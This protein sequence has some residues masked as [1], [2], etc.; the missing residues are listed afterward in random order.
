MSRQFTIGALCPRKDLDAERIVIVI[1][2]SLDAFNQIK[3]WFEL[4]QDIA[5]S[6]PSFIGATFSD[7]SLWPHL[8]LVKEG[9]SGFP[10]DSNWGKL[11]NLTTDQIHSA[12]QAHIV[13]YRWVVTPSTAYAILETATHGPVRSPAITSSLIR[14]LSS[15]PLE[16]LADIGLSGAIK[17]FP[18][19][20]GRYAVQAE[21]NGVLYQKNVE[22]VP[23]HVFAQ[24][25]EVVFDDGT[26]VPLE[27]IAANSKWVALP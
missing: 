20:P 3:E 22:V 21:I 8:L 11:P 15:D 9:D 26:Q 27:R 24:N 1:V 17:G 16:L 4:V 14:E 2:N 19:T 7:I 10:Q 5:E 6:E 18:T 13:S 12:D 23:G 25:L